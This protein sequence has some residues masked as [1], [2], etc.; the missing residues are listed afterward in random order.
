MSLGYE[1]SQL[2]NDASKLAGGTIDNS[3]IVLTASEIPNIT[4]AKIT[5]INNYAT[6]SALG[7]KAD[8]SY[9]DNAVTDMATVTYVD[10]KVSTEIAV[11]TDNAPA[12]LDTFKELADAMNNDATLATTLSSQIAGKADQ[13]YV[14]AQ[15]ALKANTSTVNTQLDQ[16]S[17]TSWVTSQLADKLEA[18]D[19]GDYVTSATLTSNNTT[20]NASIDDNDL[21]SATSANRSWVQTNILDSMATTTYV[22]QAIA[23]AASG[24]ATTSTTRSWNATSGQ[25]QF[26]PVPHTSGNVDVWI[27]GVYLLN[28]ISDSTDTDGSSNYSTA[29]DYVSQNASYVGQVIQA[30]TANNLTIAGES[31][32]TVYLPNSA[33]AGDKI[34]VRA[35]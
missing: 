7:L 11:L 28:Q 1:L 29:Y 18:S 33:S 25:Q 16:K 32:N 22:T 4:T 17:D 19:L 15:F 8:E 9:V 30:G 3:R 10:N 13:N 14:D 31:A 27:N 12:I 24:G 2:I 34:V 21:T 26:G 35:Y 5:D 23:S 6:V 20:L